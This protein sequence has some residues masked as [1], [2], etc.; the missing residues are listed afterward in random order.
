MRKLWKQTTAVMT[1]LALAASL[2]GC[3][4]GSNEE[5]QTAEAMENGSQDAEKAGVESESAEQKENGSEAGG[6][7][8]ELTFWFAN[9]DT[10]ETY[11][12]EATDRFNSTVGAEKGIHVTAEYQGDYAELNQKLQAAYI[13]GNAP[14]L[15]V[16]EIASV[17]M[18][19]EGGMIQSLDEKIAADSVDMSDFHEGLLYNCR[20][21]DSIY[22]LPFLRSTSLMYLNK[23]L[24]EE[25]GVNGDEI[26]T[27]EDVTAACEA[28]HEKTGKY[29]LS[30]PVNYWF[31][32]AFM[33]TWGGFPVNEDETVCI[34]DN[35]VSR[36]VVNYF[37]DLKDRGLAHLY[38]LSESDKMSADLMNQDAAIFFQSTGGLSQILSVA[39]E[40]GFE[41][42]TA[43]IPKGTQFGVTTGGCNIVMRSGLDDAKEK[44]AWEYMKW[45]TSTEETV[46]ASIV[47][48]YL[49]TR[50]SAVSNEK[51][52]SW[53]EQYPQYKVALDQLEISSGRPNN[54]GYVEFQD[55]MTDV[56]SEILVNDA[57]VDT[58]LA[59]LEEKG[60]ELLGE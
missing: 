45:I 4:A 40:L 43:F 26:T 33:L 21:Q 22:A 2:A 46:E 27:W 5:S 23:T 30:M 36:K 51:M 11:I 55:E 7:V 19:A 29:G 15:A 48:G 34:V 44:A 53:Y 39:D 35:E 1:A 10:V 58:S 14:E 17:G 57:D 3:G 49:A 32:E 52:V 59:E 38:P 47:T 12:K 31:Q 20:I 8:T 6:E 16:L 18:F 50:K 60:N 37:K 54:P 56:F 28:V 42:G 13:A 24:L 41:V 9:S 25:A